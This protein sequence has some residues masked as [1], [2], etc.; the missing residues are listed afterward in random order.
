M[1]VQHRALGGRAASRQ[2]VAA[3]A[4]QTASVAVD[5]AVRRAYAPCMNIALAPATSFPFPIE[6]PVPIKDP[7]DPATTGP[8]AFGRATSIMGE[9]PID[10][11][12]APFED[13]FRRFESVKD[14]REAAFELGGRKD[15]TTAVAVQHGADGASY[16]GEIRAAETLAPV[17]F[18]TEGRRFE[19][20]STGAG[21]V[22]D[23]AYFTAFGNYERKTI[24]VE[25]TPR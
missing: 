22:I 9:A 3:R 12:F 24:D 5:A 6:E 4:G 7:F 15:R 16:L 21:D 8:V 23:Y 2:R 25:I 18:A 17:F 19:Q 14:A 1:T 11:V 10:L 20:P 13:G